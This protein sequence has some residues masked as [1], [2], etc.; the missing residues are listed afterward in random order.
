MILQAM[1]NLISLWRDLWRHLYDT[2][3]MY[4]SIDKHILLNF[5][6]SVLDSTQ[7]WPLQLNDIQGLKEDFHLKTEKRLHSRYPKVDRL[8]ISR[9]N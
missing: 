3:L 8:V 1:K 4:R 9:I 6:S 7:T 5:S 2:I